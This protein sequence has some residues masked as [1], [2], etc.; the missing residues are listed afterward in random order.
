MAE[1]A[2][3]QGR[4]ELAIDSYKKSYQAYLETYLN[5][6]TTDKP[7]QDMSY[8]L[9][10]LLRLDDSEEH[11]AEVLDIATQAIELVPTYTPF[12]Q[13]VA[14]VWAKRVKYF[15]DQGMDEESAEAKRKLVEVRA[16]TLALIRNEFGNESR[17]VADTL[18]EMAK[19]L[20]QSMGEPAAAEKAFQEAKTI[21]TQLIEDDPNDVDLW[22]GR[23]QVFAELGQWANASADFT[24]TTELKTDNFSP[25]YWGALTQLGAGNRDGY[26]SSCSAMLEQFA[27]TEDE[28]TANF[29][30][31]SCA[32]AADAVDD[33]SLPVRLAKRTG[34]RIPSNVFHLNTLGAVLYRAGRFDEALARLDEAESL[35]AKPDAQANSSAAYTWYFLAMTHYRLG[36]EEE[37]RKWYDKAAAWTSSVLAPESEGSTPKPSVTWNRRLTLELLNNEVSGQLATPAEA[38]T[39]VTDNAAEDPDQ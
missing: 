24:K 28:Q 8:I 32:L 20:A 12:R 2:Y 14:A 36:H 26:L 13:F 21:Y 10:C 19:L 23:G 35:Q 4:A 31:W 1:H 33:F 5:L 3:A 27:E 37:A 9:K 25:H 11:A 7:L 18:H 34:E 30:A 16:E 17:E 39:V 38:V 22:Y 6:D 29:T 15:A